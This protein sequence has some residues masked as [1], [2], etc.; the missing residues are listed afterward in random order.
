MRSLHWGI[1]PGLAGPAA[2]TKENNNFMGVSLG[3]LF[4]SYFGTSARLRCGGGLVL[5]FSSV[6]LLST[7]VRAE[8]IVV[9]TAT[10]AQVIGDGCS[11]REAL[12]NANTDSYGGSIECARGNGADTI[13]LPQTRVKI[14]SDFSD[15]S[16]A[17][18][19]DLDVADDLT[20]WGGAPWA[21]IDAQ[22]LGRI[23]D[24]APGVILNLRGVGLQNGSTQT[25]GGGL[26]I[27]A[28]ATVTLDE[29]AVVLAKA[30]PLVENVRGAAIYAA[31]GSSLSLVRSEVAF[32]QALGNGSDG[33]GIYCDDCTLDARASTLANN[34]VADLGGSLYVS[35]G[36]SASLA[37]TTVGRSQAASG[38]GVYLAGALSLSGAVLADN[39]LDV[40]GTDLA[41]APGSSLAATYSF[42]EHPGGCVDL[43]AAELQVRSD[44]PIPGTSFLYDRNQTVYGA[45]ATGVHPLIEVFYPYLAVPGALCAQGDQ[46]GRKLADLQACQMGA[47][48]KPLFGLSPMSLPL[49]TTSSPHT[50]YLGLQFAPDRTTTVVLSLRDNGDG[51]AGGIGED[52]AYPDQVF[53]FAAGQTQQI[54]MV[55]PQLLFGGVSL[56]RK[57]RVCEFDVRVVS[58]DPL[59]VGAS[60][61]T[62]RVQLEDLTAQTA[63]GVSIPAYGNYLEFGTVSY[64]AGAVRPISFYNTT[65]ADWEITSVVIDGANPDRFEL[66]DALP[67]TVVNGAGAFNL[68]FRCK[69]GEFGAFEAR[70]LVTT[71]HPLLPQLGY[72]LRCTVAHQVSV[73]RLVDEVGEAAIGAQARF[74]VVLDSPN[75]AGTFTLELQDGPG[76]AVA[77]S[78]YESAARTLTFEPGVAAIPVNL[79]VY[80]DTVIEA[81]ESL[82]VVLANPSTPSVVL[83]TPWTASV[84]II[85]DD[86]SS[87]GAGLQVDLPE[88][89]GA[90]QQL[91]G[92]VTFT[93]TGTTVLQRPTVALAVDLPLRVLNFFGPDSTDCT[94]GED[95]RS[96]SCQFMDTVLQPGQSVTMDVLVEFPQMNEPPKLDISAAVRV[97]A[98]AVSYADVDGPAGPVQPVATPVRVTDVSAVTIKGVGGIAGGALPLLSMLWVLLAGLR[99]RV[100]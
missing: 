88:V 74:M 98:S 94:R 52:C 36:A 25:E 87:Y 34:A 30:P 51:F 21:V 44:I 47:T 56:Q 8:T 55:D 63:T 85:D 73:V 23:L 33:G 17:A 5:A 49:N 45:F 78:D 92:Q 14:G 28:G 9:S 75:A 4:R 13:I 15:E 12:V 40:A 100:R 50:V 68:D 18:V 82:L 79:A 69:P 2:T 76:S 43:A 54:W 60:G 90:G 38:G 96:A 31:P 86:I 83:G 70:V 32:A 39:G 64:G 48:V 22:G 16:S 91:T 6:L 80:N 66:V 1:W 3:S 65:G 42:A 84:A 46:H 35:A 71:T 81:R 99:R 62:V 97:Q 59:L 19:G 20:L 93:N 10:D 61:G 41:C 7:S 57:F 26:R 95:Q 29:S 72:G 24:V 27:G 58:G 77:G 89:G 67:A 37:F 53:E 11:L